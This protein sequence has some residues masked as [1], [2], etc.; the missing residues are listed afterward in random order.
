MVDVTASARRISLTLFVTQSLGSAATI[1]IF[2]IITIIGAK[3]SGRV[4]WSGVPAT[5]YLL[6]SAFSAFIWGQ[7][8]DRWGRRAALWRVRSIILERER[9]ALWVR[10]RG[11]EQ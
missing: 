5:F 7:V 9:D 11:G 6:G 1:A 4:A 3:L 8:M 2:P 10:E